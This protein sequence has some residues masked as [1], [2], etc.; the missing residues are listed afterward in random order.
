MITF[1]QWLRLCQSFV[2]SFL[3]D[4]ALLELSLG[5]L[6]R[7]LLEISLG[8]GGRGFDLVE[9]FLTNITGGE[10]QRFGGMI[11]MLQANDDK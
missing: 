10:G 4:A 2:N 9:C 7:V 11:H 3:L 6:G 5:V 8:V 1:L